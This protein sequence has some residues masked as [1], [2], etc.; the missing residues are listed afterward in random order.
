MYMHIDSFFLARRSNERTATTILALGACV[1]AY[2]WKAED[3]LGQKLQESVTES[4][5]EGERGQRP[6]RQK[7]ET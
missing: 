3:G 7:G 1:R 6:E 4:T 5:N 2:F